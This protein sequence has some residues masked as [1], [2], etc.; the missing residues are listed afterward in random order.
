MAAPPETPAPQPVS[1]V[2]PPQACVACAD[3]DPHSP[4][5]HFLV[6]SLLRSKTMYRFIDIVSIDIT[7]ITK[8]YPVREPREEKYVDRS[9]AREVWLER[10]DPVSGGLPRFAGMGI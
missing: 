2:R 7:S 4:H 3:P 5:Y 9:E 8:Y 6:N 10:P 1:P